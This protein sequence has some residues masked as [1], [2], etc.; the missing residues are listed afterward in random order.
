MKHLILFASFLF[1][2]LPPVFSQNQTYNFNNEGPYT[3]NEEWVVVEK[4]TVSGGWIK[5]TFFSDDNIHSYVFRDSGIE[6][7]WNVCEPPTDVVFKTQLGI[8][9]QAEYWSFRKNTKG[10]YLLGYADIN[11]P[12]FISILL[13]NVRYNPTT[14]R[15]VGYQ[16]GIKT[17]VRNPIDRTA[18]E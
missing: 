8:P 13:T 5:D 15:I 9:Y 1:F 7:R 17:I 3:L 14:G 18:F 4:D 16:N 6:T 11:T 2:M 10:I 12:P